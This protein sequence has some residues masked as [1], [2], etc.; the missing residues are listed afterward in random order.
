MARSAR[1]G[2]FATVCWLGWLG[3]TNAAALEADPL[4]QARVDLE[5]G[6]NQKLGELAT[7]CDQNNLPAEAARTRA[8]VIERQP[9]TLYVVVLESQ[10]RQPPPDDKTKF[11]DDWNERLTE[12]RVAQA[13]SLFQ[14]ARQSIRA[15]RP[16]LAYELVL[17][18][19][20][21]NPDHEEARRL[22]GYS[23]YHGAW[24]T[25]F[26]IKRFRAGYVWHD[27]FGW[28]Q[29]AHVARYEAGER[30]YS[31]RWIDAE[32]EARARSNIRNGW[33]VETEHYTVTT[34]VSLE[35]G[36]ELGQRLERLYSAWQQA[37][38]AFCATPEQLVRM[39]EGRGQPRGSSARH[40]AIYFR[41]R[42]EYQAAVGSRLPVDVETTGLYLSDT[43]TAYF[44]P[45]QDDEG[46]PD[47]TSLYHEATHQLFAETRPLAPVTGRRANF[48]ILEG[49]ACY[50]ESFELHDDFDTLGGT[51]SPRLVVARHRALVDGF[52]VPLGELVTMGMGALQHDPRIA[53]LYSQ[54]AGLAHFLMHA[55]DGRYRD[56]L[57]A[58]LASIYAGEDRISTLAELAGESYPRLDSDYRDFLKRLPDD[59]A[60]AAEPTAAAR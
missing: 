41:N 32:A 45:V 24:H 20:R 17:E 37:F 23:R 48:W 36:V 21:A 5:A 55:D 52:Y 56:A 25:P 6:Y 26:E 27:R 60:A 59:A 1:W 2:L 31:G 47:H 13:D 49:I 44:F 51:T 46:R 28:L 16:S 14:L 4:A 42:E 33:R 12:L 54:S 3:A 38:A 29:Q 40:Q 53:M 10:K 15:R 22:L 8:A 58:Y 18:A 50:M 34:N 30:L 9:W 57:I 19:L 35:A 39:F 7:W 43:R 11:S